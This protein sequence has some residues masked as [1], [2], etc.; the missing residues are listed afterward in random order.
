MAGFSRISGMVDDTR[1]FCSIP[2]RHDMSRRLDAAHLAG[3]VTAHRLDEDEALD[4]ARA[5]VVDNPT[6]I[7]KLG[8]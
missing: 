5:L 3:L 4:Q 2:A 6:R 8:R 7:F 1:A